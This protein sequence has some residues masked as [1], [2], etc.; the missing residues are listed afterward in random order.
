MAATVERLTFPLGE[1]GRRKA[2]AEESSSSFG[3]WSQRKRQKV[4]NVP[5][6]KVTKVKKVMK[7][8]KFMY[9]FDLLMETN[10]VNEA[11]QKSYLLE[12]VHLLMEEVAG[13]C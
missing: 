11:D 9:Q 10:G 3:L 4:K 13:D 5:T 2:E 1:G 6:L 7:V 8:V 12:S